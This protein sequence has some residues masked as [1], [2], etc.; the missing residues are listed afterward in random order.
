MERI[1]DLVIIGG[2]ISGASLLYTASRFSS[3]KHILLLEKYNGLAVLNSNAR[4]NAQTLHMGDIETNYSYEKARQV[5]ESS[6]YVLN[7]LKRIVPKEKASRMF[8]RCNKMVLGVGG[9]EAEALE[10][11]FSAKLRAL[12]PSLRMVNG[13]EIARIEPN[14]MKGRNPKER[15]SALYSP[16]GYMVDFGMLT[17]SFVNRAIASRRSSKPV[18]RLNTPVVYA[19]RGNRYYKV[20][21]RHGVVNARFV[22]FD[23]GTYS[24]YFA[25]MFG[26]DRNLSILS[27]GGGYYYSKRLLNGKVYRVQKGG[28]PF[29]AIHADPD[30]RYGNVT[31]YGPTVTLSAELELGHPDTI[32]DY[33]KTLDKDIATARVLKRILENRDIKRIISHNMLYSLPLVGRERFAE[34]EAR[35]IIPKITYKD[36]WQDTRSGGIRP[37]I[38]DEEKGKLVLG[39]GKLQREG[40]IFNITPSPGASSCLASALAD[41]R[42][43]AKNL[44]A[45]FD[46]ERFIAELSG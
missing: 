6:H 26:Y 8:R 27:I 7:Y 22:A 20:K 21:T 41:M 3:L 1:Y 37:Q 40:L 46:E 35:K 19:E 38:I 15:V 43:I 18:V 28:I 29:A 17:H 10:K 13:E 34:E 16:Y 39:E 44:D 2:G 9:F 36:L 23:A 25:K 33:I 5:S 12:F 45:R 42:Y 30:I 11:K 24:L 31:R 32:M 4:A 14:V